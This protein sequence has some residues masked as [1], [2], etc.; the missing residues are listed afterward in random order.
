[1]TRIAR[2]PS[3][4]AETQGISNEQSYI[5]DSHACYSI[6]VMSVY[7]IFGPA[8]DRRGWLGRAKAGDI[9]LEASLN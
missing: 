1:M 7:C 5:V 8:A 6:G 3:D 9:S 4:R 2:L